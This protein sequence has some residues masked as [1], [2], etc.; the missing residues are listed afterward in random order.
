MI[1]LRVGV[2]I[3]EIDEVAETLAHFGGRYMRR[4][5]SDAELISAGD[6]SPA[7][8]AARFAA[9]EAAMKA[10]G[11]GEPLEWRSIEVTPTPTGEQLHLTGRAAEC[12]ESAFVAGRSRRRRQNATPFSGARDG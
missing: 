11:D 6:L 8:V 1:E 5:F 10:I 9:K 4:V 12:A 2:D 7:D 3:V